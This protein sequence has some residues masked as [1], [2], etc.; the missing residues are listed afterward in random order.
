[1]DY[2]ANVITTLTT[3]TDELSTE[4]IVCIE[5]SIFNWT[6]EFSEDKQIIKCWNDKRF[7]HT[8]I[9]KSI[10]IFSSLLTSS[11]LYTDNGVELVELMQRIQNKEIDCNRIA[12]LRPHELLPKKWN[13]HIEQKHK[14]DDN[15]CNNRQIAKTDQ[16]ICSKCKKRECSYYELQVRS[17]DESTTIFITCLNCTH[18]WR[19][20]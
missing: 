10:Q 14:K 6:I 2:R 7:V 9:N 11:Y 12:F 13:Q 17:A 20:G 16:F 3:E 19:I 4:Q 18:R 1:M 8:Y 5:K 15:I